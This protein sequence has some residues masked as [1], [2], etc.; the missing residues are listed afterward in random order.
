MMSIVRALQSAGIATVCVCLFALHGCSGSENGNLA[1]VG[2]E[3]TDDGLTVRKLR[4]AVIGDYGFDGGPEAS[5]AKLVKTWNPD[6]VITVGDN[7]YEDGLAST[8]DLNIG[9]YY[10]EFIYPYQGTYGA[11][12]TANRFWPSLGNHDW[13]TGSIKSYLDYFKL[14]NNERYYE[15]AKGPVHFFAIDSDE[16]E[17]DGITSTSK[18]ALWLQARLAASKAPWKVVFFHHSPFSSGSQHGSNKDLQWPFNAWGA[19]AVL[20]GHDHHYERF[21]IDG[22]PYV[23]N[24]LGGRSRYS[25]AAPVDK[26]VKRFADDEGAL[27][28]DATTARMTFKFIT[29]ANVAVDSF[30][31]TNGQPELFTLGVKSTN[32]TVTIQPKLATYKPG[33]KVT[34]TAHPS[35]SF[36]FRGWTGAARGTANPLTIVMNGDKSIGASFAK[37]GTGP[38]GYVSDLAWVEA[39]NGWGP[40]EKDRSNGG[41]SKGDGP[42]MTIHGK[43]YAKGLGCTSPSEVT[44]PLGG[45]YRT[46]KSDIGIDDE[47]SSAGSAV[48]VVLVDGVS[49]FRSAT[50]KAGAASVPVSVD[51][52]GAQK[53]T[54][55]VEDAGD[56]GQEDFA[57]WAGARVGQ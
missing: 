16:H 31:I 20:T 49:K 55:V 50:M 33:T 5:V 12:A 2:D 13:N 34:L 41:Q 27:L 38:A 32:G 47:A 48:F 40:V 17:P 24:G 53:L 39:A 7:N 56:G 29:Q 35:P 11:G 52:T 21:D 18:Q 44:V 8:I 15:F 42:P 30:S 1:A 9:K 22:I 37:P 57:D 4:F 54:L 3:S 23:V 36:A 19:N 10:H 46:F 14:P 51:V 43:T 26:S 45:A 25:L 6:H 28:V